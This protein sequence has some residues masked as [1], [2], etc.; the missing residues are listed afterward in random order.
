MP[1]QNNFMPPPVP[2]LSITGVL[3]LPFLPNCSA[4]TV[5]YGYTVDEPTI[6]I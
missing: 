6:L 4:T 5:A 3:K 1:A 2:V